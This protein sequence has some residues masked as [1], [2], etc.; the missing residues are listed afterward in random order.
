MSSI[1]RILQEEIPRQLTLFVGSNHYQLLAKILL[2]F[3]NWNTTRISKLAT[4][5]I[6]LAVRNPS[7][8][9]ES[10]SWASLARCKCC[11][12]NVQYVQQPWTDPGTPA[13]PTNIGNA[14]QD[15]NSIHGMSFNQF[16]Y[17]TVTIL[18]LHLIIFCCQSQSQKF[19]S[20][21]FFTYNIKIFSKL[22]KIKTD[23]LICHQDLVRRGSY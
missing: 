23:L 20:I 9:T 10:T 17:N 1:A 19:V 16:Q 7:P 13:L 21:H 14:T 2:E 3:Q 15:M 5:P 18:L 4:L 22:I 12:S 8:F 11:A 6:Q